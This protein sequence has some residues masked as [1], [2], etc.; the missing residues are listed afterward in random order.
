M[1]DGWDAY[2]DPDERIVWEGKPT[3]RLFL[4]RGIDAFLIPFATIW[5]LIVVSAF[6]GSL[7]A[8]GI[9]AIVPLLFLL[10][11][12][13]FLI[14][15]FFHD[16][17]VRGRTI[18]ALTNKRAFIA[19]HAFGRSLQEQ[20]VDAKLQTSFRG[21]RAGRVMFGPPASLFGPMAGFAIW[22]GDD[23]SFTFR[24]LENAE[25]VCALVQKVKRGDM[26]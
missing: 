4:L 21:R 26:K 14:G 1:S 12:L 20:P 15:R 7:G 13:Y 23:G 3:I 18:Y 5:T 24:G 11:G 16:Q 10:V 22:S 2:L 19:R 8:T 17:Y 25:E 9:M 6:L